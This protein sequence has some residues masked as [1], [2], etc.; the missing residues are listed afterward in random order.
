MSW[1]WGAHPFVR[2]RVQDLPVVFGTDPGLQEVPQVP[3]PQNHR[4]FGQRMAGA[5]W[6]T[7]RQEKKTRPQGQG[8]GFRVTSSAKKGWG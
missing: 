6:T 4:C 1:G 5:P 7:S 3:V 8:G 2:Q